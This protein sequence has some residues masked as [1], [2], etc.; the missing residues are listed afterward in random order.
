MAS[1]Q[2][3]EQKFWK[4]LESDH[5]MMLGIDGAE[6]GHA[7]PMAAQFEE[8]RGPIYF[9]SGKDHALVKHLDQGSRAIATFTSK[10]HD[11][12]A[13]VHGSL[14]MHNDRETIDRLW[15]PYVAAWYEGGKDDPNIQLLRLD[16]DSA[17]I[18]LN[19]SNV[20][21]G[22]KSLLGR[23]PQKDAQKDVANITM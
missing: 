4:A 2:E 19:S 9:F 1:D 6:D 5:I 20:L 23:D 21:A 7:R 18:W 12:F 11:V 22:I 17:E 16:A 14:A 8:E 13:T 15:N 3:I 10:G